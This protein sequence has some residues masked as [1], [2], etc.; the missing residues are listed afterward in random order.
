M[1]EYKAINLK[2][3]I[4]E[5]RLEKGISVNKA[6]KEIDCD[7]RCI[8]DWEDLSNDKL[9]SLHN[10]IKLCNYY[11]CDIDYLFGNLDYKTH[12][13]KFIC[14]TTGLSETAVNRLVKLNNPDLEPDTISDRKAECE[15]VLDTINKLLE[16]T[17]T[18]DVINKDQLCLTLWH[19]IA[20]FI[21]LTD[22][23]TVDGKDSV[24]IDNGSSYAPTGYTVKELYRHALLR[25]IENRLNDVKRINKSISKKKRGR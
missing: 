22:S 18:E 10:L 24:F 19:A 25:R 8:P 14:E 6:T 4:I 23:P 7:H 2:K 12:T 9:P 11:E 16:Y 17:F 21:E 20:E 1:R 13:N 15:L 5:K 3:R